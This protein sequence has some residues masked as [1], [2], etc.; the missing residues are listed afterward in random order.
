MALLSCSDISQV[1]DHHRNYRFNDTDKAS[2]LKDF[3]TL[4]KKRQT[5]IAYNLFSL[6]WIFLEYKQ[7]TSIENLLAYHYP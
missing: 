1:N 2:S 3:Q 4:C 7:D 5:D 6:L